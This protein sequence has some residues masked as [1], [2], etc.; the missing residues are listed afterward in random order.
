MRKRQIE[1]ERPKR[2]GKKERQTEKNRDGQEETEVHE[3]RGRDSKRKR[4][5]GADKDTK[6]QTRRGK[7]KTEGKV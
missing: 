4:Q 7:K 1:K 6:R 5:A 3:L 2:L